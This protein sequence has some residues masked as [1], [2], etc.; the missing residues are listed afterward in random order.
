N[1]LTD[2]SK[3][4]I[5]SSSMKNSYEIRSDNNVLSSTSTELH[6]DNI[7]HDLNLNSKMISAS[8]IT[9]NYLNSESFQTENEQR[10]FNVYA[11]Y[12]PSSLPYNWF[13]RENRNKSNCFN[14]TIKEISP[15][16]SNL[17]EHSS[18]LFESCN[19]HKNI[20]ISNVTPEDVIDNINNN[21]SLSNTE[22]YIDDYQ[23]TN[24]E[25]EVY[26]YHIEVKNCMQEMK[27]FTTI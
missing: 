20:D 4:R 2:A 10:N 13:D 19:I 21:S 22:E 15:L 26:N 11:F 27:Y 5:L 12:E 1:E 3:V 25:N 17:Q 9:D 23:N 8:R 6:Q 24:T 16:T 14:E 18:N 7:N